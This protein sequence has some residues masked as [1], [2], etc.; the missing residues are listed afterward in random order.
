MP[1][2]TSSLRFANTAPGPVGVTRLGEF[3]P[4]R[5]NAVGKAVDD[6]PSAPEMVADLPRC[7]LENGRSDWNSGVLPDVE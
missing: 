2:A 4:G 1:D 5:R 3:R 6:C 7:G